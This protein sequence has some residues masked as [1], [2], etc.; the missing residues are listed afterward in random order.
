MRGGA[1][2]A[3]TARTLILRRM[4]GGKK[5]AKTELFSTFHAM[6][7]GG[8]RSGLQRSEVQK[9]ADENFKERIQHWREQGDDNRVAFGKASAERK[10]TRED[11]GVARPVPMGSSLL[12]A[13][14]PTPP[15][16]T[17]GGRARSPSFRPDSPTWRATHCDFADYE[18]RRQRKR[19]RE[20]NE[21][22]VG[23]SNIPT[24]PASIP[25][26]SSWSLSSVPSCA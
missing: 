9:V 23:G 20:T 17:E 3:L 1:S 11:E 16:V 10:Q 5:S 21:A 26:L 18:E 24:N 7:A 4:S 8:G 14:P 6:P 2:C 12:A 15:D 13:R 19:T 22:I 25:Y